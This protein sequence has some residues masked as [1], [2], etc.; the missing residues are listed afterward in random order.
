MRWFLFFI[1]LIAAGC[2]GPKKRNQLFFD[3]SLVHITSK[4]T[5]TNTVVYSNAYL[6][7]FEAEMVYLEDTGY[8]RNLGIP[9]VNKL[10]YSLH[11]RLDVFLDSLISKK[12]IVLLNNKGLSHSCRIIDKGNVRFDT[13]RNGKISFIQKQVLGLY[14]DSDTGSAVLKI[15]GKSV[16]ARSVIN[17]DYEALL[18][19]DPSSFRDF[20]F[21]GK[22]FYFI[23]ATVTGTQGA[24]MG[25]VSYHLLYDV[26][27]NKLFYVNSCRFSDWV[28]FG[29]VNNDGVL[30]MLDFDNSDFCTTVPSSDRATIQFY[31]YKN[32][33]FILQKDKQGIP[34]IIE[35]NT[36]SQYSQDSF[37]IKKRHWPVKLKN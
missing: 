9:Q 37:N 34:Y 22:E 28:P 13:L 30:D 6:D 1:I 33:G 4:I 35:G 14:S 23:R 7:S 19:F 21:R 11:S 10:G 25:N 16:K 32:G 24:S 29:D 36:G 31:S 20:L 2:N 8:F 12:D 27:L 5:D 18:D 15:N 3:S 26:E 17:L